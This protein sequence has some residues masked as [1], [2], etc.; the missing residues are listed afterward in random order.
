[1]LQHL[2][3]PSDLVTAQ[4]QYNVM[5]PLATVP[6]LADD[7]PLRRS[8]LLEAPAPQPPL[9]ASAPQGGLQAGPAPGP[10][11]GLVPQRAHGTKQ[12]KLRPFRTA[13][14][15]ATR[16]VK[17]GEP[18]HRMVLAVRED[19]PKID[20]S[21]RGDMARALEAGAEGNKQLAMQELNDDK[22]A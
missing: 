2:S 19:A 12:H 6:A 21:H 3:G 8:L 18:G 10:L 15:W 17:K 4:L 16:K 7:D 20:I 9:Q 1:M 13:R 11:Q 22:W 5:E 14:T